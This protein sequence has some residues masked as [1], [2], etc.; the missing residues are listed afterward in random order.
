MGAGID[1]LLLEPETLGFLFESQAVH[2]LRVY[3]Q[4]L[5]ARGVFHYRD[6]KG[7]DEIDAVVEGADGSW[8][9]FEMKLGMG[10]V[11]K[12]AENLI[13][14]TE[15]MNRPPAARVVVTPSG[16]AHKR[17]DGVFVVP[18]GTLGT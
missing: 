10:A 5:G 3:A 16:V 13:R 4:S 6:S 9:A 11:E 7:R 2:D 18:L 14:V 12:A 8:V 15:K 1:R 17:L